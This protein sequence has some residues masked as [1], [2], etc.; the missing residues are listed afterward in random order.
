MTTWLLPLFTAALGYLGHWSQQ[1]LI[2][3]HQRQDD[4]HTRILALREQ[5]HAVIN[6]GASQAADSR[7]GAL[8]PLEHEALLLY[9]RKLRT[10]IRHDLT[11]AR[12]VPRATA[13]SAY[14]ADAADC[15]A[16]A[17]RGDRLPARSER[18]AWLDWYQREAPDG[19]D[20][21]HRPANLP[22][23]W[24]AIAFTL[25]REERRRHR[26]WRRLLLRRRGP[27]A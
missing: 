16:A 2:R 24:E 17:A 19:Q 4:D 11:R 9:R 7:N 13:W 23:D 27:W 6:T 20:D 10:R 21:A 18:I 14:L 12:S 25:W 15:L 22:P 5:L 1:A 8:V 26:G 3:R